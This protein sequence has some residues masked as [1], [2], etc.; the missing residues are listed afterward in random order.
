MPPFGMLASCLGGDHQ[1]S[2]AK[3]PESKPGCL[4]RPLTLRKLL[5]LS[6]PPVSPL[7]NGDYK[8]TLILG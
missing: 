5:N 1:H 8:G 6:V 3:Q 2:C 4:I 7:S